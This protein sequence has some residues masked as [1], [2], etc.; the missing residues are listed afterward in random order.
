MTLLDWLKSKIF[1][2]KGIARIEGKPDEDRLTFIN[3]DQEIMLS[4]LREYDVWY[5]G[6]SGELLNFYTRDNMIDANYEPFYAR[7]RINYFWAISSTEGDIKR[8]HSGQPRNIVDTLVGICRFPTVALNATTDRNNIVDESLKKIIEDSGLK[9]LYRQE[10]LP[11]TLVDGWGCYKINWDKDMSDYPYV[12]YY[13]ADCVDFVYKANRIVSIIFKDYYTSANGK[14]Y[15]VAESR[16]IKRDST[17]KT[18]RYLEI[19][20]EVFVVNGEEIKKVEIGDVPMFSD[21]QSYRIDDYDQFLAVPCILYKNTS[22]VAGYGRSIFTGKIDLFDDLDQCLSQASNS[23]RA[24]TPKEYFN[25]EFLERD[26]KGL[27]KQPKAYDRKYTV[28]SAPI[29]GDG[30][31]AMSEP[32]QTTQPNIEFAKYSDQ[33]IQILLQI[34]SGIMSPATLGIDI[35]KKDNAEAQR[36]KEKV[37]IFTRNGII[38]G[39]SAIL[40]SLLSQMLCAKELMDTNHITVHDYDISIKFSEFADDSFENKLDKLGAALD[41]Q[42]ISEDMYM[43]KLYGDTLS[44]EEHD[45]EKQW[46]I[47]H[48]TK[49]RDEGMR[50]MSGG[51]ANL[52]G[53]MGVPTEEN[54]I[55]GEIGAEENV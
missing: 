20:Y 10:Q 30:N 17:L 2:K 27:P 23:V 11:L 1:G 19:S 36:E 18:G 52:P 28:V 22:K 41:A 6:D 44:P 31:S 40:K 46:L 51:G 49:P 25:S 13:R 45:R 24:S 15:M 39:E 4:K 48:H 43:D 53:M 37:T 8:T 54:E 47:E 55:N 38:D 50:G 12:M 7:N 26:E 33:A 21:L 42:T 32:V 5:T 16:T 34:I 14:K 35:A 29:G 3:N 9:D